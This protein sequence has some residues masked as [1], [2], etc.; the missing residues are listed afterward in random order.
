MANVMM[1]IVI[2]G[3]PVSLTHG[4]KNLVLMVSCSSVCN[5]CSIFFT[6]LFI[7]LCLLV[8]CLNV[9]TEKLT[10]YFTKQD[11]YISTVYDKLVTCNIV[12]NITTSH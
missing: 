1:T 4:M 9:G 6:F 7:S 3:K 5:L 11:F 10:E 8:L 2:L 12:V